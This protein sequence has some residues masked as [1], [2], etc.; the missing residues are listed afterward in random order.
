M[1]DNYAQQLINRR[2]EDGKWLQGCEHT[3]ILLNRKIKN[4]IIYQTT[5]DLKNNEIYF[6]SIVCCGISGLLVAPIVADNLKKNLVIIRKKNDKRYSPFQYEGVVPQNYIIVDDL[7]CSGE[8]VKHIINTISEDC[9]NA[10]CLG[11]YCFL[12][13]KCAYRLD[14]ML[15]KRQIGI[16]YL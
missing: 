2:T 15:C 13:D 3:T 14:P 16:E 11:V 1:I 8:T 10:K 9:P 4:K 12:K 7:I 6:D 5:S